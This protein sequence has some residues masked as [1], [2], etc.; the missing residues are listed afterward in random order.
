MLHVRQT[1]FYFPHVEHSID[2]LQVNSLLFCLFSPPGQFWNVDV[3][4]EPFTPPLGSNLEQNF[5]MLFNITIHPERDPNDPTAPVPL[6]RSF[7]GDRSTR[8]WDNTHEECLYVG[9][10]QGGPSAE[11]DSDTL[12]DSVIEGRYK[13][14]IV[15]SMFE[16]DFAYNRIQGNCSS[17]KI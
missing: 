15:S 16:T 12:K 10:G 13:D 4:V 11:F 1:L 17:L 8:T 3:S 2:L 5:D 6:P 9:N 14:Y 7:L